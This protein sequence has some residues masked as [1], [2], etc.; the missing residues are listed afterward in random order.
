ML[1]GR[2]RLAGG[3]VG[4]FEDLAPGEPDVHHSLPAARLDRGKQNVLPIP[5]QGEA[6]EV[7]SILELDLIESGRNRS[8]HDQEGSACRRCQFA[9]LV[10]EFSG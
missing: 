1:N 5:L 4:L 10:V 6:L 7:L 3:C 8:P 2:L 9:I